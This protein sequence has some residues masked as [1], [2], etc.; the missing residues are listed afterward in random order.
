MLHCL[1]FSI[2]FHTNFHRIL[3]VLS[4]LSLI[5]LIFIFAVKELQGAGIVMLQGMDTS[6]AQN[7]NDPTVPFGVLGISG[8][9]RKPGFLSQPLVL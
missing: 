7:E 6:S 2:G 5:R 9:S 4:L 8:L 1:P 3:L